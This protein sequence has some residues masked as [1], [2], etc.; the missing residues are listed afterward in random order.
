[1]Q[2]G[3]QL[4]EGTETTSYVMQLL[5]CSV[6]DQ[7]YPCSLHRLPLDAELSVS[8]VIAQRNFLLTDET[9]L[10]GTVKKKKIRNTELQNKTK[11]LS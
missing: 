3:C 11:S 9:F 8:A 10:L 1:M 7:A 4:W 6:C 2:G 5:A